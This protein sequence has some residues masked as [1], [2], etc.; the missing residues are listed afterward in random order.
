MTSYLCGIAN[1][2]LICTAFKIKFKFSKCV[3]GGI[4]K[5]V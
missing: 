2:K 1:K 4:F 5:A 3:S